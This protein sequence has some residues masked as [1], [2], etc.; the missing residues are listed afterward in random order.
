MKP[1]VYSYTFLRDYENCPHKVLRVSVLKDIPREKTKEM[2]WGNDVHDALDR[3]ISKN[4][5]L[6]A[7]MAPYE[8]YA[9][10]FQKFKPTAEMKVGMTRAGT[11]CDFFADNVYLRGKIDVS[12]GEAANARAWIVDWK[13]GKRREDSFELELFGLLFAAKTQGKFPK[14]YGRY[15]WLKSMEIGSLHDLSNVTATYNDLQKRVAEVE[16]NAAAEYWPKKQNPLCGWCP[17]LDCEFN[18]KGK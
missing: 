11:P 17:V 18:T 10:Y 14:I 15:V 8:P 12:W 1:L 9:A 7:I 2:D 3:R 16:H 5:I 6:P 13:T 4:R